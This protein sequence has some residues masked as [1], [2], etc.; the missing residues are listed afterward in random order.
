M[1]DIVHVQIVFINGGWSMHDEACTH[2]V[3]MVENTVL[4]L[5]LPP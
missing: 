5:S 1:H 3:S 4:S 2:Y